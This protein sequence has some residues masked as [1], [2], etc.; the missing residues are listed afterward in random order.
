MNEHILPIRKEDKLF[1][2]AIKDGLKKIET[3]AGSPAY[4][5]IKE[6]DILVFACSGKKIR[7]KIKT[8]HHFKSVEQLLNKFNFKDIMPLVS[9]KKEA[10]KTWYTFPGYKERLEKY[11]I[12]AFVLC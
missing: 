3:R 4:L 6:N 7:K 11:G 12:L 5:K 8:I 10:I 9:S 2:N 1:F